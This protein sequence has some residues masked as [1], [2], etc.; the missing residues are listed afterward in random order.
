[1]PDR[2]V[3]V[4]GLGYVGIPLAVLLADK[5]LDVVGIDLSEERVRDVNAGELPLKGDEPGLAQRLKKVVKAG[6]LRA[7]TSYDELRDR[8]A[9]FVCVD[10]PLD[11]QRRPDQTRL[12]T[13]ATGIGENMRKG[14][15][16]VVESTIAPGTMLNVVAP[17]L[18]RVSGMSRGK[19]FKLAHC[20]E[21]VMPGRLI[22]NLTTYDRVLGGLD[23]ASVSRATAIYSRIMKGK[24]HPTDLTSAEIV[25]TAENTYRDVQIAFA[26]EV[27]LI[28]EKL[29]VDA[30]EVRRLVNTCPFRD[31]HIPGAG[32]GGHC[33]P[34][35][36][37]LLAYGGRSAEPHIIPV[38]RAINDGMPFHMLDLAEDALAEAGVRRKDAV[39]AV[40]GASFLQDS[41]DTRNSPS[42]PVIEGM[43][44]AKELRVHDP[45]VD[46]MAGVGVTR[47]LEEA[48]TGADIA[49]FM[50]SHKEYAKLT[51]AKLKRLMRTFAVVDGRNIFDAAAMQ[52][53]GFV[54]RG[55]GKG[56]TRGARRGRR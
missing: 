4:V 5:G 29:G 6:R 31:M 21:R 22:H 23:Q 48:L 43:G 7:A 37:W 13:A 9:V 11:D 26:N 33:L 40:L 54:Y 8:T 50:V 56:I 12:L 25:K 45:F 38:A 39:V 55:L 53:A 36:P 32:V 34:K 15:L 17:V 35:D 44:T 30:F 19:D 27:A 1:M 14:T 42:V 46:E 20:P 51:P 41:G 2:D 10:T 18:E 52:K 3:A 47:D 16:V 49:V 24:L 28:C